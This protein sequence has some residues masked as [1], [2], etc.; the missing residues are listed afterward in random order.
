MSFSSGLRAGASV[1]RQWVTDY[2]QNKQDEIEN[3]LFKAGMELQ[4]DRMV[5]DAE[6]EQMQAEAMQ[7]ASMTGDEITNSM[8]AQ[9]TAS[10]GKIDDQT[11]KIA[12]GVGSLFKE[13]KNQYEMHEAKL[14]TQEMREQNL[15]NTVF[16][17]N[18]RNARNVEKHTAQ[19][20]G[21]WNPSGTSG[22]GSGRRTVTGGGSIDSSGNA[23]PPTKEE[24]KIDDYMNKFESTARRMNIKQ[25]KGGGYS[26]KSIERIEAQMDKT[27]PSVTGTA[28][29]KGVDKKFLTTDYKNYKLRGQ[30]P[31][32]DEYMEK[33][34]D[35]E[36]KSTGSLAEEYGVEEDNAP[37]TKKFKNS[38]TGKIDTFVMKN[39]KWTKQ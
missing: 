32:Y 37:K 13:K 1:G 18:A 26:V 39:G 31:E 38:K 16:N 27:F 7:F 5:T 35:R 6:G 20:N 8:L 23:R 29:P 33:K 25:K 22:G 9:V 17:R 15:R 4:Q 11:Y 36:N 10:G 34:K 21:T 19:K 14:A 28:K 2:K 30:D 3:Q 24:S 12:Y